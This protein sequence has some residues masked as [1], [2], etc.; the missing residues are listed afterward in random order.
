[1]YIVQHYDVIS[2]LRGTH[3]KG[4]G[5]LT[6]APNS[7]Y[8]PYTVGTGVFNTKISSL[9]TGTILQLHICKQTER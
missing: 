9:L 3:P 5:V 4:L 7:P 6:D 8:G 1:M 2:V